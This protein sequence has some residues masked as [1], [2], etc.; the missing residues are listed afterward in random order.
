MTAMYIRNPEN[1]MR[2][3]KCNYLS[4]SLNIFISQP[5]SELSY[6]ILRPLPVRLIRPLWGPRR[7]LKGGSIYMVYSVRSTGAHRPCHWTAI[8][9]ASINSGDVGIALNRASWRWGS[10]D[11]GTGGIWY[12]GFRGA[13]VQITDSSLCRVPN[14][15]I[16][17]KDIAG[18]TAI[19]RCLLFVFCF[20][21]QF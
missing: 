19:V 2:Q 18:V 16:K 4:D 20:L 8:H 3:I 17:C 14:G 13:V 7:A 12:L 6:Q 1:Q 5:N 11:S 21:F 9:G 15:A 10:G